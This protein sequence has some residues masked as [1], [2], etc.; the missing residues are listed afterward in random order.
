MDTGHKNSLND[1]MGFKSQNVKSKIKPA[2]NHIKEEKFE[3]ETFEKNNFDW[4]RRFMLNCE[5]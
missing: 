3:M 2:K 1:R 4:L 5:P